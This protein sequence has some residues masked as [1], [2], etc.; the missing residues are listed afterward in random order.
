MR[1]A[2]LTF[3]DVVAEP[4]EARPGE[5]FY[6]ITA[7]QL[8]ELLSALHKLGYQT[9]SSR[10]FRRWQRGEV[11]LPEKTV[12]FTFDD[13]Y[14]SHCEVVAPLLRRH[15]FS[16]TFFLTTEFIGRPGYVTWEQARRLVFL[17]MEIGSHGSTHRP[18]ISLSREALDEE[19][20]RS[21]RALE[22]KLGIP[23]LAIAAPG[24]F[25]NQAVADAVQ[26]AGFEAA[27]VSTIGTNG[28]ETQP[29]ALRRVSVHQPFSSPT[30]IAMV[31]GRRV[32][33]FWAQNQQFL[34]RAL[35][36]VLG[37]YGYERLKRLLM[38]NA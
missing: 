16:G 33:V 35:K 10:E 9:V 13:G 17:G 7:A 26:R 20:T 8:E 12:V 36:R 5:P 11:Q 30:L 34:L 19:L 22:E 14:A 29:L 1:V 2:A 23:V 6:R 24:G 3:H 27:W 15:G 32:A 28:P 38:P 4:E 18:L 21:K 25:W 37:V 31:E